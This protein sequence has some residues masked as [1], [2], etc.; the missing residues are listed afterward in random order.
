MKH[1]KGKKGREMMKKKYM[2]DRKE[3]KR[4]KIKLKK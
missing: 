3:E 4:R 1:I 2:N